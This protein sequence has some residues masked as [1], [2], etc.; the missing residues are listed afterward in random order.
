MRLEKTAWRCLAVLGWKTLPGRHPSPCLLQVRDSWSD[1]CRRFKAQSRTESPGQS[2]NGFANGRGNLF[3]VKITINKKKQR[4]TRFSHK[5]TYC[6]LEGKYLGKTKRLP[7][8]WNS[9]PGQASSIG[10]SRL[11][12]EKLRNFKNWFSDFRQ[13][14]SKW[15]FTGNWDLNVKLFKN[16]AVP[17]RWT[18]NQLKLLSMNLSPW[19]SKFFLD[20]DE[21][22]IF[23]CMAPLCFI[24]NTSKAKVSCTQKLEKQ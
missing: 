16:D 7:V 19:L 6:Y 14:L 22:Y 10:G 8:D 1:L 9:S 13:N 20:L 4:G 15:N 2:P 5:L 21:R 23:S 17:E 18:S 11:Y 12:P 24:I 3:M